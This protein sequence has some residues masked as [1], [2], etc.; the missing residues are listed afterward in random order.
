MTYFIIF[1]FSG[2]IAVLA[3]RDIYT[4]K[5]VQFKDKKT[6]HIVITIIVTYFILEI[7]TLS[8]NLISASIF[9]LTAIVCYFVNGIAFKSS[10]PKPKNEEKD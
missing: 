8:S 6:L 4:L 7:L 3:I 5:N 1:L 2:L 9:T 10:T